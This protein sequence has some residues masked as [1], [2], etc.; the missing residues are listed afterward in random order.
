M[1]KRTLSFIFLFILLL[2]FNMAGC[3]AKE[4]NPSF[5]RL[6]ATFVKRDGSKP[7]NS[8]YPATTEPVKASAPYTSSYAEPE[9]EARF[10]AERRPA[11][12]APPEYASVNQQNQS[13]YKRRVRRKDNETLNQ[14]MIQERKEIINHLPSGAI[15][16]NVPGRMIEQQSSIVTAA[17]LCNSI[18]N[19]ISF[20]NLSSGLI[21]EMESTAPGGANKVWHI[22]KVAPRMIFTLKPA[23]RSEFRVTQISPQDDKGNPISGQDISEDIPAIW[24]WSVI[25][26]SANRQPKKLLLTVTAGYEDGD[27][28]IHFY[29]LPPKTYE[30]IVHVNKRYRFKEIAGWVSPIVLAALSVVFK[31]KI[32]GVLR[33]ILKV[34][35][36]TD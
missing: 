22:D 25:P 31:E 15:S 8:S 16:A 32:I 23:V 10:K 3:V 5:E 17:L 27:K 24:V 7:S 20:S 12:E 28:R 11:A 30:I 26:K 34:K 1:E 14:A 9:L 29:S 4:S 33:K 19:K 36:Q 35:E 18:D 21:K 6:N 13:R 2:I